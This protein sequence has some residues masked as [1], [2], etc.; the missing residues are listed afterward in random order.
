MNTNG[1][2]SKVSR[3]ALFPC[4]PS[5][6]ASRLAIRKSADFPER[7][8]A[9]WLTAAPAR[10]GRNHQ[11][12]CSVRNGGTPSRSSG[13]AGLPRSISHSALTNKFVAHPL[14]AAPCRDRPSI[15]V[16]LPFVQP[17]PSARFASRGPRERGDYRRENL[18]REPGESCANPPLPRANPGVLPSARP[19][20]ALRPVPLAGLPRPFALFLNA[21][22]YF[23]SFPPSL[24]LSLLD[25]TRR[26][27]MK[28]VR[29]T[30][31]MPREKLKVSGRS[32]EACSGRDSIETVTRR[33]KN[34]QTVASRRMEI[35]F[36]SSRPL[37]K[38][39]W[40]SPRRLIKPRL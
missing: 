16:V 18:E 7:R 27:L 35:T 38:M 1:G 6:V 39:P 34:C 21:L 2:L 8:G 26:I 37:L 17:F 32:G 28:L 4:L 29:R 25:F 9:K 33:G 31:N 10:G 23:H 36:P 12:D 40:E 24:S 19:E 11:A 14:R 3:A 15:A 30:L 20:F 5:V 22:L 13:S